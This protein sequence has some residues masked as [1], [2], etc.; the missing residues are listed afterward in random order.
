MKSPTSAVCRD[1][2]FWR[3]SDVGSRMRW[4]IVMT[5][6]DVRK[7]DWLPE[8]NWTSARLMICESGACALE[9]A[10]HA[11]LPATTA[12]ISHRFRIRSFVLSS[13]SHVALFSAEAVAECFGYGCRSRA[14]PGRV[15][16]GALRIDNHPE[17]NHGGRAGI[18]GADVELQVA[19]RAVCWGGDHSTDGRR[20]RAGR[21]IS[22]KRWRRV[23][24]LDACGCR[25]ADVAHGDAIADRGAGQSTGR[26]LRCPIS[27]VRRAVQIR[28]ERLFLDE[29]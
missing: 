2:L 16:A 7:L 14:L 26:D 17:R 1:A 15:A 27:A 18:Q 13:I 3:N 9:P 25:S 4:A 12:A 19:G 23:K 5:G 24:N 22:R 11:R 20:R 10:A 8:K 21:G 28:V 6:T 29:R